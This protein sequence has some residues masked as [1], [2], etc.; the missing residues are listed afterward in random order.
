VVPHPS[1]AE[2]TISPAEDILAELLA[3]NHALSDALNNGSSEGGARGL[4]QMEVSKVRAPVLSLEQKVY[5][6]HSQLELKSGT[7]TQTRQLLLEVAHRAPGQCHPSVWYHTRNRGSQEP[8]DSRHT[9]TWLILP[10]QRK[11]DGRALAT[12]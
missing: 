1:P 11:A 3:A 12:A 2:N 4:S 6:G 5:E 10:R 9:P 7:S 8:D